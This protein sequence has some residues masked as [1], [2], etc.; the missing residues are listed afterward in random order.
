MAGRG[1]HRTPRLPVAVTFV[2]RNAAI[3]AALGVA[4]AAGL[5]ATGAGGLRDLIRDAEDPVTPLVLLAAGFATLIGSL[6]TAAALMLV[7]P[8]RDDDGG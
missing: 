5:V 4:V 6:Y 1:P 8:N 2:L 3:G 7:R